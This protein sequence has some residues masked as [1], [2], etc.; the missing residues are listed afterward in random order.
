M[1]TELQNILQFW[2]KHA[3]DEHHGGFVGAM[4]HENIPDY[5]AP[6]GVVLLARILWTFSAAH[7]AIPNEQ[8][9]NMAQRAFDYLIKFAFD[10]EF[11]GVYW[12][13]LPDGQASDSRKQI[14]AHAFVVYGLSE[15]YAATNNELA[16][17]K[18]IELFHVLEAKSYDTQYGGYIEAFNKN[19]SAIHDVRL[20]GKDK[21][22]KKTMNTHL[23]IIE[24]YAN[25][26]KVWPD[27]VLKSKIIHLLQL[28]VDYFIDSTSFHL[29]LFFTE[30]WELRPDVISYGH[31]IE[32]AWLLLDCAIIIGDIEWVG[33]M[34]EL[35][36]KIA[37]AAAEGLDSDGGFWYEKRMADQFLI[38]EKHWWPQAEAI[39]GFF[40]AW[41][42]SQQKHFLKK[43]LHSWQFIQNHI[44]DKKYG[45]WVWG[46]DANDR[47][48]QLENKIG[49]WKCPYHNARACLEMYQRLSMLTF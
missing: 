42:I 23:H 24:A 9:L 41:Q 22:E 15:F 40:N 21:N 29:N 2:L 4:N 27:K 12:K 8:Y 5:S 38:R 13:L 49:F 19:W 34:E 45:E 48:M 43:A 10:A 6:K 37:N 7:Q 28:F 16:L 3:P 17:E 47:I 18:A 31:D 30:N 33:A 36:V 1:K 11:G 35:A 14:Y 32:T 20:S 39:V 25:L 26:Y 44:I 46:V